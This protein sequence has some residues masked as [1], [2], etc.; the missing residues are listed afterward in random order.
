M[1]NGAG[2]GAVGEASPA[3]HFETAPDEV[4]LER[5]DTEQNAQAKL[6]DLQ[7]DATRRIPLGLR[8]RVAGRV[9]HGLLPQEVFGGGQVQAAL[10]AGHARFEIGASLSYA[11]RL[12][13]GNVLTRQPYHASLQ[14]N[15]CGQ[16]S[17][18]TLEL[19]FCLGL[20]GGL[21]VV[22]HTTRQG[23]WTL[24]IATSPSLTWWF[25]RHVG[26]YAGI[27][28]GPALARPSFYVGFSPDE[29]I[30]TQTMPKF[31]FAGSLGLEFRVPARATARPAAAGM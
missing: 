28:A 10:I 7:P 24:H 17:R 27:A 6:P 13:V 19:N 2:T 1:V 23:P 8:I 18:G 30:A 16:F 22:P 29:A 14:L 21:I 11:G 20:E 3:A 5:A 25:D 12:D 31:L 9:G 15:G 26:L 4:V